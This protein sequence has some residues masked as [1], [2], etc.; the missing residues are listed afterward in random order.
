[1]TRSPTAQIKLFSTSHPLAAPNATTRRASRPRPA[2]ASGSRVRTTQRARM[3]P[4]SGPSHGPSVQRRAPA[5]YYESIS[6]DSG[7]NAVERRRLDAQ[8]ERIPD[9][10]TSRIQSNIRRSRAQQ[11]APAVVSRY[12]LTFIIGACTG[13][14]AW[15]I[16]GSTMEIVSMQAALVS[17]Y[18]AD[19]ERTTIILFAVSSAALGALAGWVATY[20]APMA[21]GGGV[22]QVM[23]A[24]N[25]ARVP[26]LLSGRTLAAKIVGVCAGVGSALAI[27]PEGPMV[28]IGAGIAS[29]CALYWPRK[30]L[31]EE[32]E[33]EAQSER[34]RTGEAAS[35]SD[36]YSSSDEEGEDD[37]RDDAEGSVDGERDAGLLEA[38]AARRRRRRAARR[39][40]WPKFG[41]SPKLDAVL[42]DLASPS[43][44][45]DFVSAGAAAGLA[46][47][48][49]APIGGVLFS[50]EEASTYWS[51]RTMWRCLI[52]AA[53]ASFVLALLDLRGN[54]G[55]VFITGDSLR[56][57]TPRDYFHQLPFFVLVAAVAG[58][59]GVSFN[60]IQAWTSKFR[61]APKHKLA[62]V[63]ECVAVALA[64]VGIR[65]A[66]SAYAGHCMAPPDAWVN[67]DFGVRFNCPEGEINDI[68]TVFFVYPGRAIGWM[69]GMAEHVWGEAYGFTAQGLGIAAACY[70]VMMALAFGIAV[71]GGLFMPSLFLGAC[72]GGCAG[73]MLKTALP[74]SWDIQPG[75]YALIGATSALGGVFRSSVSLVVIMVESTNGQAFVF[76]IIV[77]VIVSNVVGNYFAHGIYH[78]ELSRSKTVAYL[79]RDASRALEGKT[80]ADIMAV[81]PAFLPE[82]ALRDAVKSLLEHTSHNG[83]PVVDDRGKLSGLILRSQL[84]VLLAADARD[85]AP[86]A[87]ASTQSRLDLEMRTAHIRRVTRGAAPGVTAGVLDETVD[88]IEVER[89]MRANATPR[90]GA[91][92]AA[93]DDA[94]HAGDDFAAPLLDIKTYMNPAPLTVPTAFPADRAHGVFHS[95]ALRHLLVVDDDHVVRGVITRKD[96]IDAHAR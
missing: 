86:G 70:L 92:S 66:A 52:C 63:F 22:T 96:L 71:P 8:T 73:L 35:S 46:A 48:F 53:I 74:E 3:L 19:A 76:A 94:D 93:D 4:T 36:D 59:F 21:S 79:P 60:K 67:D 33:A 75:L 41:E 26:G 51:Q 61:P 95:L 7:V 43:T 31:C 58:L 84:E 78:A 80:A 27:G 88:D 6:Y 40:R 17:R 42:L 10:P 87:D 16:E 85:A 57:T 83:F 49:G 89:L 34:T 13:V 14:V 2:R 68:A 1:M 12:A 25:G 90:R 50:F 24:L 18:Y 47:A 38:L 30:F 69:F 62:R 91:N 81:P 28:H 37:E 82:V 45:R 65:F 5:S 15:A 23:A 20:Y 72:T 44:H 64:T 56:P 9:V 39:R 32:A 54:P 29:V 11:R 55:M 77:A